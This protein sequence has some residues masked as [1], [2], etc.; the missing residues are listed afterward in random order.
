MCNLYIYTHAAWTRCAPKGACSD[1]NPRS[2]RFRGIITMERKIPALPKGLTIRVE[3]ILAV[4]RY[5]EQRRESTKTIRSMR[6]YNFHNNNSIS[7]I[8]III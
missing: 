7:I 6:G 5:F 8:I 4:V 2:I 1:Y 3:A